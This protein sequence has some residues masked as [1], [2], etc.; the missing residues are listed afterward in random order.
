MKEVK[1]GLL[2]DED[3][4]K[5]E[6]LLSLKDEKEPMTNR[7]IIY[8]H[9][10]ETNLNGERIKTVFINLAQEKM[11]NFIY[12]TIDVFLL[13][14][15][16]IS[17]ISLERLESIYLADVNERK[18]EKPLILVGFNCETRD[19]LIFSIGTPNNTR[20]IP[21]A[22]E[23]TKE[24]ALTM[25][26]TAFFEVSSTD[27]INIDKLIESSI[28]IALKS[29][30]PAKSE[31]YKVNK[32]IRYELWS[33]KVAYAVDFPGPKGKDKMIPLKVKYNVTQ[34]GINDEMIYNDG[35]N[36]WPYY[37]IEFPKDSKIEYIG[38]FKFPDLTLLNIPPL[39]KDVHPL[40]FKGAKKIGT[41]KLSYDIAGSK[42]S[43]PED[44]QFKLINDKI[45]IRNNEIF[46]ISRLIEGF[47]TIPN[48]ITRIR[49]YAAAYIQNQIDFSFNQNSILKTIGE[50]AFKESHL[51]EFTLPPYCLEIG[52]SAF[53]KCFKLRCIN[54]A[55]KCM[56]KRIL[57]FAFS[58]SAITEIKIPAS[59]KSLGTGCFQ[60]CVN[61]T[62]VTFEEFSQLEQFPPDCFKNAEKLRIIQ[63]PQFISSLSSNFLIN[64]NKNVDFDL[65]YNTFFKFEDQI[66]YNSKRN[67]LIYRKPNDTKDLFI[68][69]Y[70]EQIAKSALAN[71][72]DLTEVQFHPDCV[73]PKFDIST[74][75]LTVKRLVLPQ[76]T[77]LIVG[78]GKKNNLSELQNI[79]LTN[80]GETTF[81]YSA[82]DNWSRNS[83]IICFQTAK[84]NFESSIDSIY[85]DRKIEKTDNLKDYFKYLVPLTEEDNPLKAIPR[86]LNFDNLKLIKEL[87]RG[88]FGKVMLMVN[89]VNDRYIAVKEISPNENYRKTFERETKTLACAE[90]P[91]VMR[92]YG[93]SEFTENFTAFIA[94]EYC[95]GGDLQQF[96]FKRKPMT[97]TQIVKAVVGIAMGMRYLHSIDIIHRDLKP[98]NVMFDDNDNIKIGDFG[99]SKFQEPNGLGNTLD[100]GSPLY[101]APEI[102][103][104]QEYNSAV[105]VYAFGILYFQVICGIQPYP[106]RIAYFALCKLKTNGQYEKIPEETTEV[107]KNIIMK[108]LETY[109]EQRPTFNDIVNLM[110]SS[111]F[112]LLPN[113]VDVNEI[114]NYYDTVVTEEKRIRKRTNPANLETPDINDIMNS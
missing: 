89:Q 90:H 76:S 87:G 15:S 36:I 20:F 37:K 74:L 100:I 94:L 17:P 64:L 33:N 92:L 63:I 26:T 23:K 12:P 51:I 16:L 93:C 42:N 39:L 81:S 108:C 112:N 61:L 73:I 110:E 27:G 30:N 35:N 44:E 41:I 38:C 24:M 65:K 56:L 7:Q 46:L 18:L 113:G 75:P 77:N 95:R 50:G 22:E 83:K 107:S 106:D 29:Q 114:R 59:V 67:V 47:V 109:P 45:L 52:K 53:S 28:S 10:M 1:I 88:T 32:G 79:I 68:Q 8:E 40:T 71:S 9:S 5:N 25:N 43:L 86:I 55:D 97:S 98:A 14:F 34:L 31:G 72:D 19:S 102:I 96:V 48:E 21:I 69:K 60:D 58:A 11:R 82:L 6:F 85:T 49:S 104:G 3:V 91:C 54:F 70:V 80:L 111:N 103:N 2:G 84:I 105:D 13:C 57:S 99:L 78:K 66:L 4:G 62:A 101:I